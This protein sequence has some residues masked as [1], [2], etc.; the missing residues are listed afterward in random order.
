MINDILAP[1]LRVEL[2][3]RNQLQNTL[4]LNLR[5]GSGIIQPQYLFL[6]RENLEFTLQATIPFGASGDDFGGTPFEA[7]GQSATL[8]PPVSATLL[9]SGYF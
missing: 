5:D 8:H 6:Y 3:A 4:I 7:G 9:V 1:G 2:S